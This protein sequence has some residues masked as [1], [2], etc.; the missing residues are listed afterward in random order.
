MCKCKND[1]NK[2][3]IKD[4]KKNNKKDKFEDYTLDNNHKSRDYIIIDEYFFNYFSK[5]VSTK[6]IFL[7]L[8]N[9]NNF[10]LKLIYR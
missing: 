5:S 9:N 10:D 1:N 2:L 8:I 7:N 6:I 4:K 3:V